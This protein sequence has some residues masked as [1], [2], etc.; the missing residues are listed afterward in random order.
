MKSSYAPPI[1]QMRG[2]I[3]SVVGRCAIFRRRLGAIG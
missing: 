3:L 2:I 1:I